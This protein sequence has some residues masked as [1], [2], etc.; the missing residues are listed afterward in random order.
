M[1]NPLVLHHNYHDQRDVNNNVDGHKQTAILVSYHNLLAH[2]NVCIC[3]LLQ[4]TMTH[5]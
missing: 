5:G 4:T 1:G 2:L 3:F